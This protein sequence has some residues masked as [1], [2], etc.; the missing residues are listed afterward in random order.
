M[1][2]AR[3][4]AFIGV[5]AGLYAALTVFLAPISYSYIQVRVAEALT[6]LPYLTPLAIP[7]LFI[8]VLIANVF[9]G[10]GPWDIFGG[11]TLTLIA[12]VLTYLLRRT[13]KPYLAPLPPVLVNAFGV[14]AY[15]QFLVEGFQPGPET[16]FFFVVTIGIGE[17]IACYGIGYP[18][19]RFLL[20]SRWL[21]RWQ[22]SEG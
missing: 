22:L 17:L 10:F 4:V 12:A 20:R 13:G 19:L 11:S 8:G 18:L 14:S 21:E 15:L 9:G 3:S 6:V 7:G 2:T 1:K 5:L 16:Y